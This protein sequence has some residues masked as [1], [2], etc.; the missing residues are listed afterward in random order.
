M[1]AP[2]ALVE[3]KIPSEHGLSVGATFERLDVP[4]DAPVIFV[5]GR[6][7]VS[8]RVKD[9]GGDI[10]RATLYPGGNR[11]PRELLAAL[12]TDPDFELLVA[13]GEVIEPDREPPHRLAQH[14]IEA[15]RLRLVEP[16]NTHGRAQGV[17]YA[18]DLVTQYIERVP[19]ER[20]RFQG[21]IEH[22]RK[23]LAR[24]RARS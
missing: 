11:V 9:A 1:I 2:D 19:R 24:Q 8:L 15:A 22:C 12:T 20:T 7:R 13:K 17:E 5:H 10:T 23:V 18:L 3:K 6:A 16:P 14:A 4:E 21:E